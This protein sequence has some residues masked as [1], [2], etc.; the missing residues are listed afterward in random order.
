MNLRITTRL[1][2]SCWVLTLFLTVLT[3][4]FASINTQSESMSNQLDAFTAPLVLFAFA[5]VGALVASRRPENAIGW[6]FS[7]VAFL[8]IFGLLCEGYAIFAVI[9]YQEPRPWGTVAAWLGYWLS[10][11]SFSLLVSFTL[12]LFPNGAP[13]SRRWRPVVWVFA[14]LIALMT[15]GVMFKPG[16]MSDLYPSISNPF[17]IEGAAGIFAWFDPLSNLF[18]LGLVVVSVASVAVRFRGATGVARQ[19]LKWFTSAGVLLLA[20]SG[21]DIL[22]NQLQLPLH[23]L[24]AGVSTDLALAFVPVAVGISILK[25]RLYDIDVIIRRTLVYGVLTTALLLVYFSSVVLLQALLGSLT[26]QGHND[27]VIVVS[28]LAIAALFTPLRRRIQS[29]IDRRFYRRK[30]DAAKTLEAFSATLRD[31]VDLDRLASQIV[32]V[33]EET[34]QPMHVSLWL[35]SPGRNVRP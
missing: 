5:T 1:A 7:I 30:Y 13:P 15:V 17:G 32:M 9:A 27:L 25:Y 11:L 34:I 26:G 22:V 31:E 33:V 8:S 20:A 4:I 3:L 21:V 2:M 12:L 35:A 29:A 18:F 6:I 16:Q 23:D 24:I 10:N 14:A 19:Q 28:T